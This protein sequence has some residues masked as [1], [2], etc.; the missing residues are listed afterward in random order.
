[1]VFRQ[2]IVILS[3]ILVS[4]DPF[5]VFILSPKPFFTIGIIAF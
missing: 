4:V 3:G 2:Y 5:F 1:M